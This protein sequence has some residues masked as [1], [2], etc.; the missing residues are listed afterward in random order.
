MGKALSVC[1]FESPKPSTL[2][3]VLIALRSPKQAADLHLED[4]LHV[5]VSLCS[6]EDVVTRLPCE[7]ASGTLGFYRGSRGTLHLLSGV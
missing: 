6:L 7:G 2:N 3:Q 1:V 5:L 4:E